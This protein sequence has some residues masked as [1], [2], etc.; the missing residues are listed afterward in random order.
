[1]KDRDVIALVTFGLF[2]AE[3]YG[4]YLI[5]KNEG[6]EEFKLYKPSNKAIIHTVAFVGV[7]S[8]LNGIIITRVKKLL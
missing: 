3:A 8:I 7:F 1:M 2:T 5:A 4:H 6:K